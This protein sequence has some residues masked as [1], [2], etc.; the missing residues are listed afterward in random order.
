MLIEI[1][2]SVFGASLEES[3]FSFWCSSQLFVAHKTKKTNTNS[4]EDAET[5]KLEKRLGR[6]CL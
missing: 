3:F 1:L 2:L 4:Y 6:G 5:A